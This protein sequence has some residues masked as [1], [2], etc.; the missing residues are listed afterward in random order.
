MVSRHAES[1]AVPTGNVIEP[2]W[3]TLPCGCRMQLAWRGCATDAVLHRHGRRRVVR[4]FRG[5]DGGLWAAR[6]WLRE[7]EQRRRCR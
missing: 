4:T 6:D 2:D 1:A 5:R 7:V 3:L